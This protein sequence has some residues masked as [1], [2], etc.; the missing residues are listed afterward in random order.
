MAKNFDESKIDEKTRKQLESFINS[1][2]ADIISKNMANIDKDK[3][4]KMF[5]SLSKED[6]K[7]GLSGGLRNI[8]ADKL[9]RFMK[10]GGGDKK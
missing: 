9:G 6:I 4:L 7:K 5:A 1:G 8:D 10:D 3:V 2:K